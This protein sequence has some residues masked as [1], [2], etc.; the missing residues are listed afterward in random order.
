M[1]HPVN[2]QFAALLP[3]LLSGSV[4]PLV[5]PVPVTVP[6]LTQQDQTV[7]PPEAYVGKP[8][9]SA[10]FLLQ[11]ENTFSQAPVS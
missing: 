8:E 6:I 2:Q 4:P 5:A 10:G 7:F 1:V 11:C 3:L 9:H